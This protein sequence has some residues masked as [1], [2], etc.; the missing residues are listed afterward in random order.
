MNGRP[1]NVSNAAVAA[2]SSLAADLTHV[3]ARL[4]DEGLD[5]ALKNPAFPLMNKIFA[6]HPLETDEAFVL[7]AFLYEANRRGET[8]DSNASLPLF[9]VLGTVVV[10]VLLNA[11]WSR[12]LRGVMA[13]RGWP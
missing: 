12:R 1:V 5:A 9:G 2:A 4:G 11:F 8:T 3:F 6:D 13:S 10:L 7:R